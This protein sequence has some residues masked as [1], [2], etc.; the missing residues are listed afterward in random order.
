MEEGRNNPGRPSE[1]LEKQFS[2]TCAKAFRRDMAEDP[3]RGSKFPDEVASLCLL[4]VLRGNFLEREGLGNRGL[5]RV[6]ANPSCSTWETSFS[7]QSVRDAGRVFSRVSVRDIDGQELLTPPHRI[8]HTLHGDDLLS[9][10]RNGAKSR[11]YSEHAVGEAGLRDKGGEGRAEG[12]K[13]GNRVRTF[14]RSQERRK[15]GTG[16]ASRHRC[17]FSPLSLEVEALDVHGGWVSSMSLSV[18]SF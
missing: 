14:Q 13:V 7:K 12:S 4:E 16:G 2:P 1:H 18:H 11:V 17:Y 8:G 15:W 6:L 5:L 3:R 10:G 9:S